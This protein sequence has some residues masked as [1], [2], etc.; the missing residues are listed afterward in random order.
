ML[1]ACR[2]LPKAPRTPQRPPKRKAKQGTILH[3]TRIRRERVAQNRGRKHRKL[4]LVPNVLRDEGSKRQF[5]LRREFHLRKPRNADSTLPVFQPFLNQ[6]KKQTSRYVFYYFVSHLQLV[7]QENRKMNMLFQMDF[8]IA[9][10]KKRVFLGE[11]QRR[12]S[13]LHD[14]C[15]HVFV[16]VI[17]S[18]KCSGGRFCMMVEAT[19]RDNVSGMFSYVPLRRSSISFER[20]VV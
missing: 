4:P 8:V 7:A 17:L 12:Y 18:T 16:S 14:S 2:A 11:T 6:Y 15:F 3:R 19:K 5:R 20:V 10:S 9:E 1:P 13:L